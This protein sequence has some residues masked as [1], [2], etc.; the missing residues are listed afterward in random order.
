MATVQSLDNLIVFQNSQGI[1]A[2]GNLVRVSRTTLIFEVYNPYSIVQLSEVLDAVEIRSGNRVIYRGRAVVRNLVNTGLMLIVSA[3]LLGDWSDLTGLLHQPEQIREQVE[4]FVQ[5]WRQSHQIRPDYQLAVSRIRS[6]LTELNHWLE[7]VDTEEEVG[8]RAQAADSRPHDYFQDIANSVLPT[9]AEMFAEF[10]EAAAR[11]GDDERVAH[12]RYVQRDLHPLLLR[13]PFVHRAFYK[14]LGYAGDYEMVNMMLRDPRE[15]PTTYSRIINTL[16]LKTGPALAH[17]NRI[18][19]LEAWLNGHIE[20]ASAAGRTL[21]ILNVGCG[22]C[23]ELQRVIRG[24]PEVERCHIELVDFNSETLA[25]AEERLSEA[26]TESGN[27][28]E[29]EFTHES[30][31]NLLR[32]ASKPERSSTRS[33]YDL[34]Y[35]AGLFDYLSD[36]VCARLLGLFYQWV[37]PGGQVLATNVHPSNTA[38]YLMEHILEWYLIY[39]DETHFERIVPDREWIRRVFVDSTGIN[40]FLELEKPIDHDGSG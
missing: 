17:R 34:V 7:H 1:Q 39:R 30:V 18:D 19:V 13:A 6:F 8:P 10:E 35:C 2:R 31:H 15:G 26:M 12:V 40:V 38:L 23:I 32:T 27:R 16:H 36:K 33:A 20:A 3:Q 24:N 37:S 5:E 25:Y 22:P 11:V 21:R 4:A 9:L 29:I 28:P 14:P